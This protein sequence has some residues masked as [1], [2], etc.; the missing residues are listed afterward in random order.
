MTSLFEQLPYLEAYRL[1]ILMLAAL[2][3]ILM[4]Q[5]FLTAPLAY[6]KQEETP[7]LP[8]QGGH[9][10]LSFRAVRTYQNSA[11]SLPMFIAALLAAIVVGA[12]PAVVNTAS[13]IYVIARLLFW[14]I[15]YAGIGR[16]AGGP[17]TMIYVV[18]LI[19]NAVIAVVAVAGFA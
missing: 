18:S 7:G 1:S 3:V 16:S 9:A 11:E 14:W 2:S 15:Y 19:A 4:V 6:V 13:V 5:N 10:N 17:R 12:S 8:L